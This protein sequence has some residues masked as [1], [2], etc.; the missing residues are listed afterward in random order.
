MSGGFTP[1]LVE[2]TDPLSGQINVLASEHSM[3]KAVGATLDAALFPADAQLNKYVLN[4]TVVAKVTATG[5]YGP[6]DATATD[7][8]EDPVAGEA[9]IIVHGG[10]NLK[11]GDTIVGLLYHGSVL[12]ARLLNSD[13]ELEAALSNRIIFQ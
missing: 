2:T 4:G 7:G 10:V 1:K 11:D 5:K 12:R 6:Y 9:G 13:A 3:F 8:R